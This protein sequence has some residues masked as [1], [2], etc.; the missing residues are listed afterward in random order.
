MGFVASPIFGL[1]AY[2]N[3]HPAF[4]FIFSAVVLSFMGLFAY[5]R[6]TA[7]YADDDEAETPD[8]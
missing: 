5:F 2:E 7:S 3:I 6:A 4:P 8:V 1:W